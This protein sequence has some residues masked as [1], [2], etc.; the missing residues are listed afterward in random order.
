[1]LNPRYLFSRR[2]P[3]R[4]KVIY[5]AGQLNRSSA[6]LSRLWPRDLPTVIEANACGRTSLPHKGSF[7]HNPSPHKRPESLLDSTAENEVSLLW[8]LDGAGRWGRSRQAAKRPDSRQDDARVQEPP[9]G[10]GPPVPGQLP[11]RRGGESAICKK[12]YDQ[13][14]KESVPN[15]S[16]QS[17]GQ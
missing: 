3:S 13:C 4:F 7:R 8:H 1:M 11:A 16:P 14:S 2:H 5:Y 6:T 12:S 9:E 17:L 10:S 15:I